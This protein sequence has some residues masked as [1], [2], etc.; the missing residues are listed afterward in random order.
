MDQVQQRRIVVQNDFYGAGRGSFWLVLERPEPSVCLQDPG[1]DVDLMVT[2]DTVAMHRVGI[3]HTD[4]SDAICRDL[5]QIEGMSELVR[6]FP[7]RLVLSY[8]ADISPV[9]Q[10]PSG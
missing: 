5:I 8:F 7:S 10:V 2:A 1:F 6:S 9:E 4:L 3:G